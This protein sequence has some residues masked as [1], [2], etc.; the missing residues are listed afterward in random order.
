MPPL[1]DQIQQR[2]GHLP[3]ELRPVIV[4]KLESCRAMGVK[5]T[6]VLVNALPDRVQGLKT[7]RPFDRMDADTLRSAMIDCGEHGDLAV[8]SIYSSASPM[9]RKSALRREIAWILCR[10]Q[11]RLSC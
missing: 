8:P 2:P 11:R 3:H 4:A 6:E 9:G 5:A 7:S 10:F 1:P